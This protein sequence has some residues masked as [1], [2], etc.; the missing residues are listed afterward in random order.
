M[1][2]DR[3]YA[4]YEACPVSFAMYFHVVHSVFTGEVLWT[5]HE[6]VAFLDTLGSKFV[7]NWDNYHIKP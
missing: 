1:R 7:I 5:T 6:G 4:Q 2:I 3:Y